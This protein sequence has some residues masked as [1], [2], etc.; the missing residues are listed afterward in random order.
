MFC[1]VGRFFGIFL[2]ALIYPLPTQADPKVVVSIKPLHSIVA[3]V[4]N[5]IGEPHLLLEG[6]ASPHRH[7]L[8]PSDAR[9]ISSANLVVWVGPMIEGFL[10]R[11]LKSVSSETRVLALVREASLV[12]LAPRSGGAWEEDAHDHHGDEHKKD[13][14]AHDD[15]DQVDGHLWLD[16]RN[17]RAIAVLV[18]EELAR[19][20]PKNADAYRVNAD[21]AVGQLKILED[22]IR[23]TLATVSKVPYVVFHDAYQYFEKRFGTS[24]VGS[25]TVDGHST[26]SVRRLREV[27]GKIRTT[28]AACVFVEPQFPPKLADTVR[29]GTGAGVGTLD[30]LG[31]NLPAG[32][33]AYRAL[34]SELATNLNRCLSG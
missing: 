22:E 3:M 29:E 6:T 8:K 31:A 2:L 30:P 7:A 34:L 33:G 14:H 10:V 13:A 9:A 18:A 5:G 1:T 15:V 26:P 21:R 27:R 20:D 12:R 32:P 19:I 24:A 23:R 25:I 17:G 28:G 16:P 11:P 4:M